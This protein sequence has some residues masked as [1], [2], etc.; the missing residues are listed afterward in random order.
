MIEVPS[1]YDPTT[2]QEVV[3]G[4]KLYHQMDANCR[5]P[6]NRC[7][8][9]D[10]KF[11]DHYYYYDLQRDDHS[12]G[13]PGGGGTDGTNGTNASDGEDGADGKSLKVNE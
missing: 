2:A 9:C 10:R 4:G 7:H 8:S 5:C 11:C 6:G 1:E 13:K 3:E 12:V